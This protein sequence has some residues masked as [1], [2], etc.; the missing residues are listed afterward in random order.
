MKVT[1]IGKTVITNPELITELK[2]NT[3]EQLV[4]YCARVSNPNNQLSG[5]PG[6]LKYCLDAGHVSIFEMSDMIVEIET[7]RAIAA[8][9]LRHWSFSFQEFSQRY[10]AVSEFETYEA[11]RQD[12]KNR[13]NSVDNMSEEDKQWFL[14]AQEWIQNESQIMYKE[15]LSKGIA[16]EQAR[17]LLPLSTRTKLYMKS[18]LR[19]W[20]NYLNLRTGNGTQKEHQDI[21]NEIKKIFVKEFPV[22]AEAL[23]W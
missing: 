22:I 10:A 1:M 8:Q 7:S 17:F 4:M 19:D 2:S 11:R 20:I 15:A 18:N 12:N 6:L 23:K 14:N 13:Q 21:A 5:K 16:K 9:I 3:P